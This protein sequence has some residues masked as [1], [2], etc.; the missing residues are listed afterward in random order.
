MV[1]LKVYKLRD[2]RISITKTNLPLIKYQTISYYLRNMLNNFK[3]LQT[4]I[5]ILPIKIL[6]ETIPISELLV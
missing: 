6:I 3:L 4:S 1:R 5:I 2:Y